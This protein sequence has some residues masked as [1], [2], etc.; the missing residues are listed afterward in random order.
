MA[1]IAKDDSVQ[2]AASG[3][4]AREV[5]AGQDA[6]V[7]YLDHE[8]A[9]LAYIDQGTGPVTVVAI[10]GLPGSTRDFRWLAPK[11]A[12]PLRVI[13]V[14]LPGY[15]RS[16]RSR[17][18]GMTISQRADPIRALIATLNLAPVVLL[19]HS[20]G[21]TVVAHLSR[22]HPSLVRC[23]VLLAPPG[24]VPHSS[25]RLVRAAAHALHL[26]AARLVLDPIG[27]RVFAAAGFP[28]YLTDDERCHT[29][30]DDAAFDFAEHAENLAHMNHPTLVAWARDDPIIPADRF[31]AVATLV[32]PGPRLSY[33]Q[34]G[35]A[36]QKTHAEELSRASIAFALGST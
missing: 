5:R 13:R 16:P 28:S 20:S 29:V 14:D 35:H 22:H 26:P 4:A 25:R 36:I 18:V 12:P 15:G 23:C 3:T 34:G 6:Q 19:G 21:G 27:R 33:D 1:E 24:P 30:L 2:G 8:G 9:P 31:L 17:F 32:P 11:L 10:P 7:E